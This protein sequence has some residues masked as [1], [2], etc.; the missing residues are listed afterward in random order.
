MY[1]ILTT[2][3]VVGWLCLNVE[4]SSIQTGVAEGLQAN[5]ISTKNYDDL[6]DVKP[7]QQDCPMPV[8]LRNTSFETLSEQIL[9]GAS[10]QEGLSLDLSGRQLHEETL[11]ALVESL[12][13]FIAHGQLCNIA[14]INLSNNDLTVAGVQALLPIILNP[15]F[16]RMNISSNRLE[17][18]DL[19]V[20][21]GTDAAYG[22]HVPIN[23][24]IYLDPV[25]RNAVIQKLI[26]I[27][28]EFF[29]PNDASSNASGM[30]VTPYVI[31]QHRE[32]Y[33][34]RQGYYQSK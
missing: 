33:F 19:F 4:A 9:Q 29:D 15:A 26:W 11:E 1:T 27:P 32:Y 3:G 20:K 17:G 7:S 22:E 24:R 2:M 25:S 12:S 34:E 31:H 13:D 6:C 16:K 10:Y 23:E 8:D 21:L 18:S 30:Y 5:L 14:E 28:R